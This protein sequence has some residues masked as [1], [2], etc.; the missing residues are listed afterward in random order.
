MLRRTFFPA[1]SER[2][3][4]PRSDLTRVKLGAFCPFFGRSPDVFMGF[5]FNVI[6]AIIFFS[7]LVKL[8]RRENMNYS[9]GPEQDFPKIM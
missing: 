5:P 3:K 1:S 9:P 8:S 2:L 4:V 6:F 7:N